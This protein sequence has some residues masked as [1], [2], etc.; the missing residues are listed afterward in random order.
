MRYGIEVHGKNPGVY[1]SDIHVS[2]GLTQYCD[3]GYDLVSAGLAR[4]E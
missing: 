4:L 1:I 3:R 2:V